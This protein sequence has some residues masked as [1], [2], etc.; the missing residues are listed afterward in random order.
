[1][2]S[3]RIIIGASKAV[4][5]VFFIQLLFRNPLTDIVTEPIDCL[6]DTGIV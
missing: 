3:P 6:V 2:E 5:D 4:G 1:M